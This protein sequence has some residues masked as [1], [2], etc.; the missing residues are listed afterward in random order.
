MLPGSRHVGR[1]VSDIPKPVGPPVVDQP[2]R[3]A[4]RPE[5]RLAMGGQPHHCPLEVL[6]EGPAP[7][8]ADLVLRMSQRVRGELLLRHALAESICNI[9][10]QVLE[11]IVDCR[12]RVP[13]TEPMAEQGT[14]RCQLPTD[15]PGAV[16]PRAPD[17][18]KRRRRKSVPTPR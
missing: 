17:E 15:D 6:I 13:Q 11:E 3:S 7:L 8:L 14:S 16:S 1:Q 12:A 9:L 2:T 5:R 18:R 10:A 4:G